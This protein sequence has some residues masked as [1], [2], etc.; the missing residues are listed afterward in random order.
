MGVMP[1][2]RRVPLTRSY[3]RTSYTDRGEL[4]GEKAPRGLAPKVLS[5]PGCHNGQDETGS[6]DCTARGFRR[7]ECQEWQ[8]G[9]TQKKPRRRLS[10]IE[11]CT[12]ISRT[13]LPYDEFCI[14]PIVF[15]V[16]KTHLLN[17]L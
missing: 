6:P 14:L 12:T 1:T 5:G 7:M 10:S 9:M 17:A 16:G 11:I 13:C 8:E 15:G 4:T 2:G 3:R